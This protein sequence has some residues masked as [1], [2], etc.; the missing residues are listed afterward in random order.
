[1]YTVTKNIVS[2]SVILQSLKGANEGLV[3]ATVALEVT[4]GEDVL[5]SSVSEGLLIGRGKDI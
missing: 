2:E 3:R 1:M 5:N 4:G